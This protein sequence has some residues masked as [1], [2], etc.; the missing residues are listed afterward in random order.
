MEHSYGFAPPSS[1]GFGAPG[2][3]APTG[4]GQYPQTPAPAAAPA[5][6]GAGSFPQQSPP[7]Q[8]YSQPGHAVPGYPAP[9]Q[10]PAVDTQQYAAQVA[11]P[12]TAA[13]RAEPTAKLATTGVVLGVLGV[14]GGIVFGWALPLSVV[15]VVLGFLARSKEPHAPG[16]ALAA[17]VT[18]LVGMLL[19]LGWLAYSIFTWLALTAS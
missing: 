5:P 8:N 12:T 10:P 2:A 16:V 6:H 15:A 14:I 19:S 1:P 17:I 18:G 9:G 7:A 13:K 3:A 4:Y 11:E